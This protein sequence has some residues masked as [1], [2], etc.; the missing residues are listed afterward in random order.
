MTPELRCELLA[1]A[2]VGRYCLG[3][4]E[5]SLLI[6][7]T[8]FETIINNKLKKFDECEIWSDSRI[9]NTLLKDKV[10]RFC[11]ISSAL[12]HDSL[13][14]RQL[15]HVFTRYRQNFERDRCEIMTDDHRCRLDQV[16]TRLNNFR[17]L[18]NQI[19]H[20]KFAKV[21]YA[22][23]N[24]IDD[25]INYIW[26]ELAPGSFRTYQI[27]WEEVN[28]DGRIIET[29]LKH[30]ADYMIRGIDEVDIR[31]IDNNAA[32]A[33]KGWSIERSDLGNLFKLRDK[34]L[35]VKNYLPTWLATN[36][37]HLHTN[38]LTTIDTTSA[39][40]WM[41]LTRVNLDTQQGIIACTV[42]ILATPLDV[43]VYMDF[44]G[45]AVNDRKQYYDF[46]CTDKYIDLALSYMQKPQ[47]YVFDTEWYCFITKQR[48]MCSWL[49]DYRSKD[50]DAAQKEAIKYKGLD[51]ITWNRM[52]HG[53]IFD[54]DYL[55][56][57]GSINLQ[58]I[59]SCLADI[60]HFNEVFEEFRLTIPETMRN[61]PV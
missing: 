17:W 32:P 14:D 24:I 49:T 40:I 56:E 3:Y 31:T 27:K 50:I 37:N 59:E 54:R 13:Y 51:K 52:L 28:C 19:M 11:E 34:L 61:N 48:S 58:Q 33:K 42:S 10:E 8:L 4:V 55:A 2:M 39:Y 60:I 5:L 18:R 12:E 6:A 26:R 22:N 36:A 46:L 57:Y 7:G 16:K 15:R 21:R 30:D 1:K 23:D 43:R 44:G 41:P 20:G 25:F 29:L 47:F 53:Y 38:T 35:E 9:E 45:L